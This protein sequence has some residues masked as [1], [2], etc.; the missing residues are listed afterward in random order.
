MNAAPTTWSPAA[1]V[2]APRT[3]AIPAAIAAGVLLGS[4]YTLSPLT[5]WFVATSVLLVWAGG[6]GLPPREQRWVRGLLIAG[7]AVRVLLVGGLFLFGTPDHTWFSVFF[8]DEQY[9]L[10]RSLRLRDLWLRSPLSLEALSD[11]FDSYGQTSYLNVIA[12][13]QLLAGPAPYGIH[14]LNATFYVAGVVGMH[15][16]VRMAFGR[17]PAIAAMCGLLFYPTLLVWSASGLKE[18]LNF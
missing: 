14:L 12:Y 8:G 10:I 9:V 17:V 2:S 4:A 18:S 6:R 11:I 16:L 7:L 1:P 5:V 15:R 13:A 3:A